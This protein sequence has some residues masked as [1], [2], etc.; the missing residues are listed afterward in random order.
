MES[1]SIPV[2]ALKPPTRHHR[3]LLAGVTGIGDSPVK[4][5]KESD[6]FVPMTGLLVW[7]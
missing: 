7:G 1:Y 6:R 4:S 3:L 2:L 5:E